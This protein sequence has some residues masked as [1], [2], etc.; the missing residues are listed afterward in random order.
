MCLTVND[1][2]NVY[3]D[4]CGTNHVQL[5]NRIK[6]EAGGLTWDLYQ[7]VHTNT[8][9]TL[10]GGSGVSAPSSCGDCDYGSNFWNI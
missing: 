7:N 3:M 8:D 2:G 5:W 4:T 1:A 10:T 6:Y 9:L